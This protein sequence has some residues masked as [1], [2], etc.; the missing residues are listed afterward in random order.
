MKKCNKAILILIM[1]LI[2][3]SVYA[4][5]GMPVFDITS[6]MTAIDNL[7]AQYDNV[8]NTYNSIMNQITMI[9]QNVERAKNIDWSKYAVEWD[10]D[11]DI[12][13]EIYQAGN[14]LNRIMNEAKDIGSAITKENITMLNG[15]RYSLQQLFFAGEDEEKN[16]YTAY[17]GTIEAIDEAKRS[18]LNPI[19]KGLSEEERQYITRKYGISPENYVILQKSTEFVKDS[20][21]NAIGKVDEEVQETKLVSLQERVDLILKAFYNTVDVDG[22]ITEG[23]TSETLVLMMNEMLAQ[24]AE[25][26]TAV[27]NAVATLAKIELRNIVEQEAKETKNVNEKEIVEN[28]NKRK[29]SDQP[30]YFYAN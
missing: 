23:A 2:P 30:F 21:K 15:E 6:W 18:V 11:L 26:G 3:F 10:G 8:M 28:N 16:L 24:W 4:Q 17:K 27:D 7:Y 13:N 5:A 19:T 9:Q 20:I 25:M 1:F 22:H 12:R 14:S 29:V